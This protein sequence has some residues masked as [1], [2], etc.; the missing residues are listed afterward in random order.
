SEAVVERMAGVLPRRVA[1]KGGP[2]NSV[3]K[4]FVGYLRNGLGATTVSA[5]SLRARAGMGVSV[6][7]SWDEIESLESGD[8][9]TID[10]VDA[11]LEIG[12][13]PWDNYEKSA[14]ALGTAMK[15]LDFKP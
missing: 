7:V 9:W 5:W 12:N 11:R 10:T 14:T 4:I 2:K 8:Q 15:R 3:G 1:A 6:P 13:H